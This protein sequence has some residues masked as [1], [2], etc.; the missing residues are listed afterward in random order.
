MPLK[1][2]VGTR[3]SLLALTQTRLICE[4]LKQKTGISCEIKIIETQG[5]IKVDKAL[6]Q[7][8]GKDFFTKELDSALINKEV[9]FVVHS[10]KDLGSVRPQGICLAAIP[11]R[12]FPHDILLIRNDK[13]K[14]L[15]SQKKLIIGTSSPRRITHV[16]KYLHDFLPLAK[17]REI[18]TKL[19]RGNVNTR[20]E[21]LKD[22]QYDAIILA[23]AGLE[24][25]ALG[26]ESQ[27][28]IKD[29]LQDLNFMVLP[30]SYFTC[31]PAQGALA[32]ECLE[33]N[34]VL[35]EKLS[36]LTDP[37]SAQEASLEKKI[38][39]DYGGGCHLPLGIW[40]KKQE[41]E[42]LCIE[43]GEIESKIHYKRTSSQS[44]P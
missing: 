21:K 15:K 30:L 9:D 1:Y 19:L 2:I 5:D 8:E 31:A 29:L 26:H 40:V 20:I 32:I 27:P 43:N 4:E 44:L 33:E 42:T 7:L 38:F 34:T 13:S 3:G 12:L 16:K 37:L 25:L 36:S 35:K 14:E 23:F 17:D 41:G 24:R 11:K 18:E 22:N 10:Y 6:W 39:A 28:K